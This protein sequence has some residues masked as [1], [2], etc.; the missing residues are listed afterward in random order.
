MMMGRFENQ[1]NESYSVP[2][3]LSLCARK[4]T[5]YL[6]AMDF[7]AEE[8]LLSRLITE[9]VGFEAGTE[10]HT[11]SLDFMVENAVANH[12]FPST[13]STNVQTELSQLRV[14]GI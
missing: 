2:Y 12:N 11:T 13:F 10:N 8:R 6:V 1:F 5:Q 14:A 3:L 7:S 4:R 9:M